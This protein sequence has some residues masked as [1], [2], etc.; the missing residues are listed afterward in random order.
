[1]GLRNE[2]EIAVVNKSSVFKPLRFYCLSNK[3]CHR[4]RI[5]CLTAPCHHIKNVKVKLFAKA[6]AATNA[7]ANADTGG[8]TIALPGL[9]P[10]EPKT[11]EIR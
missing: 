9:R 10:G 7:N 4:D 2:F 3:I 6:D 11:A 1:M 5:A 8:S